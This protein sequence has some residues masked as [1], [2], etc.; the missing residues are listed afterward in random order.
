MS[1]KY[2]KGSQ[3]IGDLKAA[4]DQQRDTLI[5]FGE[6]QIE[7]Q[8]S[9][10]VRLQIAN[11]HISSSLP[12]S[13]SS[14]DIQEGI[15]VTGQNVLDNEGN[16]SV[17]SITLVDQDGPLYQMPSGD[18]NTDEVMATDGAG[19]IQFRPV[20][21]LGAASFLHYG[22]NP[23]FYSTP[24]ETTTVNG[25]TNDYGYRM[26]LSGVITHLTCQ[27]QFNASNGSTYE[28]IGGVYKNNQIVGSGSMTITKAGGG[29][30]ATGFVKAFDPP[31]S[32]NPNE[33]ITVK[34]NF[35]QTGISGDDLAALVRIV[36]TG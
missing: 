10:S 13:A 7:F 22:Y 18:G 1:Y 21:E 32:F 33:T 14:I 12:I 2:S 19:Q 8:T 3:V 29:S 17:G 15:S 34:V 24:I 31:I 9:G 4:D 28:F 20:S 26:P 16:L 30:G 11:H 27:L 23:S 6:D 36:T 5:D 25:S 35:D